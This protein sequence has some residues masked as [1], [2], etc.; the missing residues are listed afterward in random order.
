[1]PNIW[2]EEGFPAIISE[3][4]AAGL[5]IVATNAR[6]LP[7]IVKDGENE[8][9]VEPQNSQQLAEKISLILSDKELRR[10]ISANNI[11]KAKEYSWETV[12]GKLEKVYLNATTVHS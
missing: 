11:T 9:I 6:G 1:M 7:E 12:V 8:C 5:P 4:M 3:A 2:L 10:K